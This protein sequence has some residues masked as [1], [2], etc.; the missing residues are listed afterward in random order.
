MNNYNNLN[1]NN[2]NN[3]DKVSSILSISSTNI[4]N[5]EEIAEIFVNLKLNCDITS[6]NTVICDNNNCKIEKGC[7]ILLNK[8]INSI[9]IKNIWNPLKNKYNLKCAHY[10][11]KGGFNGCIYDYISNSKCPG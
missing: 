9:N 10:E 7:R 2:C 3:K 1:N 5:C 11:I 8:T 4:K 6:N